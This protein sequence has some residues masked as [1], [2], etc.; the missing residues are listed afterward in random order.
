[1]ALTAK[2]QAF[3]NGVLKGMTYAEAYRQAGYKV[4]TDESA[5][6]AA[7]QL[8]TNIN[9]K[10]AI[11]AGQEA[12]QKEAEISAAWV[13]ER[14]KRN[15]ERA[16]QAEPITDSEGNPTGEYTYQGN[17]VNKALELIGKHIGMFKND[18]QVQINTDG[19]VTIYLPEKKQS[20]E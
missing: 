20:D 18:A 3:V 19:Q 10:E 5:R 9:V 17:V 7:S 12:V 11:Q 6:A 15:A 13:L 8:L 14:L 4:T 1:M 2:Q 16:A